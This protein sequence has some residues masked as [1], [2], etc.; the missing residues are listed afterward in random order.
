VRGPQ[1]AGEPA[2]RAG[3]RPAAGV[4]WQR[5]RCVLGAGCQRLPRRGHVAEDHDAG[6]SDATVLRDGLQRAHAEVG[7]YGSAGGHEDHRGAFVDGRADELAGGVGRR[8]RRCPPAAARRLDQRR[9]P[10]FEQRQLRPRRAARGSSR[11]CRHQLSAQDGNQHLERALAAIGHGT[12]IRDAQAGALE[13][14]PDRARDGG[15]TEVGT[16]RAGSHEDGR[17][18]RRH[19]R[20]LQSAPRRK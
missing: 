8:C 13:A 7:R 14:A 3:P 4:A 17:F 19:R 15:G 2:A 1:R 12:G 10:T 5:R 20:I 16:E 6:A 9:R 18:A 11:S